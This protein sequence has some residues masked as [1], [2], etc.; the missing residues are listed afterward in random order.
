MASNMRSRVR[1]ASMRESNRVIKMTRKSTITTIR[2]IEFL[3]LTI[4]VMILLPQNVFAKNLSVVVSGPS[5]YSSIWLG[6][7]TGGYQILTPAG[8]TYALKIYVKNGM[9]NRSLHNIQILT[10]T[11]PFPVNT[12]KPKSFEQVKPMEI[13][14]F[15]INMTV[16]SNTTLGDHQFLCDVTA[17]EFPAGIFKLQDK[18]TV[19][20]RIRWELYILYTLLCIAILVALFYRKYK[21]RKEKE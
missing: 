1:S 3:V 7:S 18:I 15:T 8:S 16:P 20:K 14:V 13:V 12:V 10:D 2:F 9:N 17:D 19:V 4:L 6:I 21:L 11:F 5:D